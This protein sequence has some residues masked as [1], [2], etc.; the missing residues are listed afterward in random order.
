MEPV[1]TW[2][3]V[4][5]VLV[6]VP[7]ALGFA[8]TV[9]GGA[10]SIAST[11]AETHD[12]TTFAVGPS[13]S[14]QL[15]AQ[16]GSVLIET[17]GD[18]RIVVDDQRRASNITRAAAAAVV[19]LSAVET[20]RQGDHVVVEQ[21]ALL[22]APALSRSENLTITV[23]ARTDLDVSGIGDVRIQGTDGAVQL[24]TSGAAALHDL[25][26]RGT[27]TLD[28]QFG[29]LQLTNVTVAGAATVT[30][31]VGEVSFDGALE[32]GGSSLDIEAGSGGATVALP[33]PTDAR[34]VVTTQ[35]GNF[36]PDRTWLFTPDQPVNPHV[37]TADL[38]PRPTGTVTV[39]ATLG[40]VTFTVR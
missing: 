27:S 4:L 7:T 21:R 26:L 35:A 11:S 36:H 2:A 13:P 33:S 23:P 14:L 19:S 3:R 5:A 32:P 34:A 9:I 25:T 37:W 29:R 16:I 8:I 38:G 39:H 10:L 12:V 18:G 40:T 17:G 28:S 31:R 1:P 30:Q 20:S 22:S 15:H 24:R 6:A